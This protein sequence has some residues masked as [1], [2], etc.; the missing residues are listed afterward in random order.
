MGIKG[1]IIRPI[2][3]A[4]AFKVELDS[5]NAIE[6]QEKIFRYLIKTARECEFG[7]DHRFSKITSY[8]KFK[9][10]VPVRDYEGFSFYMDRLLKGE[11]NLFWPGRPIYLAKTSG[12]TSGVKYIP[13]TKESAPY[14]VKS[15]RDAV[16]CY[17]NENKACSIMDGKLI[18]LSGSPVLSKKYGMHIG[19]LSGIV[20]HLIP[21]WLKLSQVPSYKTNCIEDWEEKVEAITHETQRLDLRMIS[22]IPAWVQMYFEKLLQK[23]GKKSIIEIFPNFKLFVYGGVNYE[24]YRNKIE[25]LIGKKIPSLETYPASEGF[26]AFQNSQ[27]DNGLLLLTNNGIFYE[28]IKADE[29]FQPNAKRIT[30]ADVELGVNYAMIISTNAG[31]WAYSI[32]D[33]VKFVSKNPYKIIVT[34]RI[35]H[36][37]S[38]FGEHVISEETE[39][40]IKEACSDTNS[41]ITE[42]HVAPQVTPQNGELPYH[43]WFIE[44]SKAPENLSQFAS[45]IDEVMCQR[46]I[47]YKDLIEGKILQKAKI[48]IVAK[49]TFR[50]YMKSEGKLGGQNKLPRLANDRILADKLTALQSK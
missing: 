32:G 29:Y 20:N 36:F 10:Q 35:K 21:W 1:Q 19:R 11:K 42:F 24:P 34:G 48:T 50:E 17:I 41:E 2:A 40:A 33:T 45:K 25:A 23:T 4:A 46:N 8:R 39:A 15:A 28:F 38:A 9:E 47:Y 22:G 31:L 12:T 44:F 14:H 18:F 7:K 30:L 37:I 13:I 27:K 6:N 43:E 5:K 3:K 26:F 49:D 16:F